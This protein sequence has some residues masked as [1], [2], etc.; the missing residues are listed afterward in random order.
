M[1]IAAMT[2]SE[3]AQTSRAHGRFALCVFDRNGELYTHTRRLLSH[4]VEDAKACGG[5]IWVNGRCTLP[6]WNV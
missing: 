1:E 4:A 3:K 6:A 5:E 2:N